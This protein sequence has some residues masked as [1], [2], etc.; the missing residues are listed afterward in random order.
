MTHNNKL[1]Q[2]IKTANTQFGATCASFFGMAVSTTS[3][4]HMVAMP[5]ILATTD[6]PSNTQTLGE[7]QG[8][9]TKGKTSD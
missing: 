8:I 1:A 9:F 7:P 5:T 4:R 6:D 3:T 2:A